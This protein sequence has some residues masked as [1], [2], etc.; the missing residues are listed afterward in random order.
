[1]ECLKHTRRNVGIDL[2]W[3]LSVVTQLCDSVGIEMQ[4]AWAGAVHG[5]GAQPGVV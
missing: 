1:M 4:S 2:F 5:A 3:G